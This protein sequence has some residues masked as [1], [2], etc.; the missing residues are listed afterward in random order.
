MVKDSIKKKDE[1]TYLNPNDKSVKKRWTNNGLKALF[2]K[3][4]LV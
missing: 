2:A 1:A 4:K 3:V